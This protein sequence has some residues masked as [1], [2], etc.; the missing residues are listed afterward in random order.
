MESKLVRDRHQYEGHYDEVVLVVV[1]I[2]VV[3]VVGSAAAMLEELVAS[4]LGFVT[5]I[6][7]SGERYNS[8][9]SLYSCR[10]SAWS[11]SCRTWKMS[12]HMVRISMVSGMSW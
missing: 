7:L 9:S 12:S 4:F 6:N 2:V 3:V 8:M 5:A 11:P 1:V 10:S